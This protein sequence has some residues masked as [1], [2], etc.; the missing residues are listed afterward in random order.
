MKK[1]FLL[2]ASLLFSTLTFA[3]SDTDQVFLEKTVKAM[4]IKSE[5]E[6]GVVEFSYN[7]INMHLISDVKH[8]RMRI[9]TPV[10]E[11][12]KL[13]LKHLKALLE[14]NFHRSL[15]ARYA[16]SKGVLYS[17]YIHPLSGLS[18]SQIKSAVKQVANLAATFGGDY[19]SGE[20]SYG[21][22]K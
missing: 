22:Q 17:A 2:L 3:G 4:A 8:D 1:L 20:L 9:I 6:K 16:V 19:S 7:D 12:G 13:T 10:A 21:G 15:D 11:Y 18:E 5:G 14:S